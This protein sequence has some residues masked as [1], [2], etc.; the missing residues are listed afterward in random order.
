MEL[1]GVQGLTG[2]QRQIQER[3]VAVCDAGL[4]VGV[5]SY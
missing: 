2:G 3:V 5:S 4:L 1:Q